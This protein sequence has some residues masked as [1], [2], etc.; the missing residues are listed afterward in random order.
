MT[1]CCAM[2]LKLWRALLMVLRETLVN[3]R[4]GRN[5]LRT[6]LE[7]NEPTARLLSPAQRRKLYKF[8]LEQAMQ[9]WRERYLFR[10]V[11]ADTVRKPPFSYKKGGDAP[12]IGWR[13]QGRKDKLINAIWTGKIRANIPSPKKET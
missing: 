3:A 8:T 10:R 1:C 9:E 6:V 2:P 4:S 13:P 12:M 5:S 11:N 7:A